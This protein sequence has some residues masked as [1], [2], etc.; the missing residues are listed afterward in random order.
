[1]NTVTIDW[2]AITI[3]EPKHEPEDT[4]G[5][6]ARD[7]KTYPNVPTNGY[8]TAI[9]TSGGICAMW[10]TSRAEMGVHIVISGSALREL[11]ERCEISQRDILR[12]LSN[13]G[14]RFTR[15][16]LAK[17]VRGIQID[18][19]GIYKAISAGKTKG[20]ARKFAQ[21]HSPNGGN[22]IYVGSRESERFIRIYDK[23]AQSGLSGE[24]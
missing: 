4:L 22:T 16:D 24:Q 2:L 12:E 20:T 10:H 23:A 7:T 17:D 14:G 11:L 15:L 9:R 19:D 21:M 3:K 1:M 5:L 18:L 6:I 13:T 8:D